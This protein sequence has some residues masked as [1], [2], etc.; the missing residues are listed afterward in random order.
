M[1]VTLTGDGSDK[2]TAEIVDGIVTIVEIPEETEE[3]TEEIEN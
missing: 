2:L 1:K 3:E